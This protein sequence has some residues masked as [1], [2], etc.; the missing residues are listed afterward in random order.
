MVSVIMPTY[1]HEAYI[2]EAIQ[3]VIDQTYDNWELIIVDDASTDNTYKIIQE[4]ANKEKRIKVIK[5]SRNY[6]PLELYKTYNEALNE[7]RGEWIAILEGDDVLPVYSLEERVKALNQAQNKENIVL[8]HGY[9]G[10]IW[11]QTKKVDIASHLLAN[12]P[13]VVNNN[14]MG[15]ALKVFLTGRNLIYTQTV[16]VK[17]QALLKI[18]GFIQEPKEIRLVDFPTWVFISMEGHFLF[19]PEVLGFWRRHSSSITWNNHVVILENYVKFLNIFVEK[20]FY[21]LLKLGFNE[22]LLKDCVGF[23][24]ILDM[25]NAPYLSKEGLSRIL[26]FSPNAKCLKYISEQRSLYTIMYIL[27]WI[28]KAT[29]SHKPWQIALRLKRKITSRFL[30]D[31]KPYFYREFKEPIRC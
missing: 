22:E 30:S 25:L 3:S 7:S 9:C 26:R 15:A 28:V 1:N 31:Y 19:V 27:Y 23:T 16:M 17:K 6:G 13:E 10:R 20:Y 14:P 24:S 2:S 8:I 4:F 18:G 29:K 5:H 12:Y 21:K 11:E